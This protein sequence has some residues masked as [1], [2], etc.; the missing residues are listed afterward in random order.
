[1]LPDFADGTKDHIPSDQ[2]HSESPPLRQLERL[3][4]SQV[5][6][7]EFVI[8]TA[9]DLRSP[10]L[11]L[12]GCI[13]LLSDERDDGAPARAEL[14]RFMREELRRMREMIDTL[15]YYG[16]NALAHPNRQMCPL[17]ALL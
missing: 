15:L 1:R 2:T 7:E 14:C 13:E 5:E 6:T 4:Q 16:R 8:M 11:T 10:L 3:R 12:S 17:T 9:H